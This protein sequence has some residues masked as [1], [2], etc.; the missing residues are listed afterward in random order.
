MSSTISL[1][2][3]LITYSST[4][5]PD[6]WDEGF[7]RKSYLGLSVPESFTCCALTSCGLCVNSHLLQKF[8]WWGLSDKLTCRCKSLRLIPLPFF[9]VNQFILPNNKGSR[10]YALLRKT[11]LR[12]LCPKYLPYHSQ[13][14]FI[15][16]HILM[17]NSPSTHSYRGLSFCLGTLN[18]L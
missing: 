2:Y 1:F 18:I 8:L 15:P 12:L 5:I 17:L 14:L 9:Q 4:Q 7:D 6:T 16:F 13:W 10:I 11:F 3:N